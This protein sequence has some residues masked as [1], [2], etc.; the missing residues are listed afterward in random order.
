MT[1]PVRRWWW[2][3]LLGL[4]AGLLAAAMTVP[5]Q[6]EDTSE[7]KIVFVRLHMTENGVSLV[8]TTTVPGVL[9]ERRAQYSCGD[10]QYEVASKDGSILS[11]GSMDNPLVKRLEYEDPD[12]PGQLKR[13]TVQLTEADFV[14]R[15]RYN[16]QADHLSL[17]KAEKPSG[18]MPRTASRRLIGTVVLGQ[19]E[20]GER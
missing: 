9:K 19:D 15:L 1:T 20:G 18:G 11:S 3:S 4:L 17:Y 7:A 5:A 2:L 6:A 16:H 12:H 8:G 10:V 14:I 13:K